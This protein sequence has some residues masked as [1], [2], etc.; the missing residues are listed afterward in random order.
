VGCVGVVVIVDGV[1]ERIDGKLMVERTTGN[2]MDDDGMK[3]RKRRVAKVTLCTCR[4][5]VSRLHLA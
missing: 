3:K 1:V 4:V 5:A 2:R